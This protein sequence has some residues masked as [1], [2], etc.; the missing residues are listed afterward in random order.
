MNELNEFY[1]NV[2]QWFGKTWN[3]GSALKQKAAKAELTPLQILTRHFCLG[4]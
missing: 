4:V 1:I 2:W 3:V